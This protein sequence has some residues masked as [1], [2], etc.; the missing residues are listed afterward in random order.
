MR[1]TTKSLEIL[2]GEERLEQITNLLVL[3]KTQLPGYLDS[4]GSYTLSGIHLNLCIE[5]LEEILVS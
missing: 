2:K 5:E 1:E 4:Q 3:W